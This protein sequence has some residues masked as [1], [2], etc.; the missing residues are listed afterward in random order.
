MITVC[1]VETWEQSI[2]YGTLDSRWCPVS[3]TLC[4]SSSYLLRKCSSVLY[5]LSYWEDL[6]VLHDDSDQWTNHRS[7]LDHGASSHP[8]R[9][10]PWVSSDAIYNYASLGDWKILGTNIICILLGSGRRY[11][12][13]MSN[14]RSIGKYFQNTNISKHRNIVPRTLIGISI[15]SET[16][17]DD[18]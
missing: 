4:Q 13:T 10:R 18:L 1:S 15:G 11:Q 6:P 17:D 2:L 16:R 8:I 3:Q 9:D 14:F 12:I 5:L 7:D